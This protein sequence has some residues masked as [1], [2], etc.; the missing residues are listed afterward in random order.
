MNKEIYRYLK[1]S[2]AEN[3]IISN[4]GILKWYFVNVS[5]FIPLKMF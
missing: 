1:N 4:C 5:A 2:K 3:S